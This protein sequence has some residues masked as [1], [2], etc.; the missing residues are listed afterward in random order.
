M[1]TRL[2]VLLLV[3][4]IFV[5]SIVLRQIRAKKLELKYTISWLLLLVA[6]LIV[7]V[8]PGLLEML[9]HLTGIT[10]PINMIFFL[11]FIFSLVIIFNLTQ[12]VSKMSEEIKRLTQRIALDEKYD[13]N[14]NNQNNA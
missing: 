2:Q 11:G 4:L 9:A 10:L 7:A 6:L 8:F 3:L 1:S 5:M 13:Q 14:H 12:A